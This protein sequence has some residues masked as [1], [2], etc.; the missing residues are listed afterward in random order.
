MMLTAPR[1]NRPVTIRS[2]S[3]DDDGRKTL[4]D[5]VQGWMRLISSSV[6]SQPGEVAIL[7]DGQ[8]RTIFRTGAVHVGWRV[9]YQ[10]EWYTV[11]ASRPAHN[12][13]WRPGAFDEVRLEVVKIGGSLS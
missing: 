12:P 2:Q 7:P 11:A 5:E 4:G 13:K 6:T 1:L 9:R 3:T 8:L 10:G